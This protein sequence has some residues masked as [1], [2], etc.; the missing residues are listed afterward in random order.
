MKTNN[1]TPLHKRNLITIIAFFC[2]IS[3]SPAQQ[4]TINQRS[5]LVMNG[6]VSLVVNNA[7][8]VNNG[9]F[10]AG[11]GEVK[12]TGNNDTTV[13]NLT[14]NSATVFYDLTISK[15]ANGVAIKSA[16]AVK[17][18]LEMQGGNLY[19][20][21]NITLKSDAAS[22]ARV[23]PVASG[24]SI[25]GKATIE[26]YIPAKRAWRMLTAPVSSSNTIFQSWQNG[27]V[28]EPGVNT[29][30]TGPAPT[31]ENGLDVSPQNNVSVKLW[32]SSTQAFSNITNTHVPI[33]AGTNG[34]A[35]NTGYFIFVRGD[36]NPANFSTAVCNAT[37]LKSNG[38]IQQGTQ[39]FTVSSNAGAYTLV[40][41]PYASPVNFNEVT[42]NNVVN[43]FYVWDPT[44][45]TLGGYVMLDDLANSGAYSKSVSSSNQTKEIQ[46][47]QAIMVQTLA[48]GP[49][50]VVFDETDKA[51]L[52]NTSVFRP[53]S[54][55]TQKLSI[56]LDIIQP[57]GT[58][59][60]ADGTF[61]EFNDD[62]S[63][64]IDYADA[65]K[66]GNINECLSLIRNNITLTAERRTLTENPD[67]LFLKLWKT[68]TGYNYQF[69]IQPTQLDGH[70]IVLQDKYTGISTRI[71]ASAATTYHF[72]V[73]ANTASSASNRFFITLNKFV[74]LP[75]TITSVKA[76]IQNK[77]VSVNWT[78]ENEINI[79][80][81]AV[82]RSSDGINFEGLVV[83]LPQNTGTGNNYKMT[84]VSPLEGANFYRIKVYERNG[85]IK[86]STIVKAVMGKQAGTGMSIFPNPVRN[87][88]INLQLTNQVSGLYKLS[89]T[90]AIGQVIYTGTKVSSN[91]SSTIQINLPVQLQSGL[92]QLEVVTP[93]NEKQVLQVMAE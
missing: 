5:S 4:L 82:E 64:A 93:T 7:S 45:N 26:R 60:A 20:N 89:L 79:E 8:L 32:N 3:V 25:I 76:V 90:N 36:R 67:T 46:S 6:A 27:G 49:A 56:D 71:N 88:L 91:E 85:E 51:T 34:Q 40:G 54:N 65:L 43:R 77:Q 14:G 75:V 86:Y 58:V 15:T 19:A 21:N 66:F 81:Y 16:A 38:N 72:S 52:N 35:D 22:T 69:T 83:V 18:K 78:V 31:A 50:T 61:A 11:N 57:D 41:N 44:L 17:N 55:F 92:Y 12:F 39:T 73:D 23:A 2:I 37:T 62:F 53:T 10:A 13:S 1:F 24:S 28:Y 30:V 42:R 29:F 9:Q 87:S 84:D 70:N 47:G 63:N 48:A 80:K 74:V 68:N 33:S 59:V